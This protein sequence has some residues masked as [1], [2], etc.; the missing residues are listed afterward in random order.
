MSIFDLDDLSTLKK[1]VAEIIIDV[2]ARN[3]SPGTYKFSL[4]DLYDQKERVQAHSDAEDIKASIRWALY[5][6]RDEDGQLKDKEIRGEYELTKGRL[7]FYLV[8]EKRL[9]EEIEKATQALE[10]ATQALEK[11]TQE[12]NGVNSV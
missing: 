12:L 11:A 3:Y 1:V 6:L 8:R 10:K 5:Q 4:Q 7:L 9:Q 2:V